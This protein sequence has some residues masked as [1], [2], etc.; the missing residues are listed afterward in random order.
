MILFPCTLN[1]NSPITVRKVKAEFYWDLETN[2]KMSNTKTAEFRDK[3][4]NGRKDSSRKGTGQPTPDGVWRSRPPL[5]PGYFRS[6]IVKE[7]G[8]FF[9]LTS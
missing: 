8:F 1:N 4:F 7:F 5:A 9:L 2:T 3:Y 6:T